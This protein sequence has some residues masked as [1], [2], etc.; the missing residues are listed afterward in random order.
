MGACRRECFEIVNSFRPR[1]AR[2]A[3]RHSFQSNQQN[4]SN[5]QRPQH[6]Q[7]APREPAPMTEEIAQAIAASAFAPLGLSQPLL[8]ALLD[9]GYS[10]PTP[11][12]TEVIPH[13]LSGR[14]V[15]AGAQTGT[16]KTAAFVLPIL[17]R[18]A[19]EPPPATP[20]PRR[21]RALVLT[22]TRELASQIA[23][24]VAAYGRH[25][26]IASRRRVRRRQPA[27]SRD[28]A[29]RFARHP[30]RDARSSPRS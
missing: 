22:P 12:Q 2:H 13:A 4:N 20:G 24:S 10:T 25:L 21:I 11:V 17:Q 23:D 9:E 8:R 30:R 15:I 3:R 18:L 28:G 27:P 14:D 6:A 16:G 1:R 29:P 19:A 5:S 26:R 7:Q